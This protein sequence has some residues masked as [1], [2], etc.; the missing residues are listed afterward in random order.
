M[1]AWVAKDITQASVALAQLVRERKVRMMGALRNDTPARQERMLTL[2]HRVVNVCEAF[3]WAYYMPV[4]AK[5]W[6]L[7]FRY[8][9]AGN[10]RKVEEV[11]KKLMYFAGSYSLYQT[12]HEAGMSVFDMKF[13]QFHT[14][15]TMLG[16]EEQEKETA[17]SGMTWVAADTKRLESR[18]TA[19][20]IAKQVGVNKKSTFP[21]FGEAIVLAKEQMQTL[22]SAESTMTA[23]PKD[24]K[25]ARGRKRPPKRR[26]EKK[27]PASPDGR[28]TSDGPVEE[29]MTPNGT[30]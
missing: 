15:S 29:I 6:A 8:E 13:D 7:R 2:A 18:K 30:G 4:F 25:P 1:R 28:P 16:N 22:L 24:K 26:P 23:K 9:A 12:A 21:T 14:I 10:D 3:L 17:E 27:G 5:Y 20:Q 19:E 11:T